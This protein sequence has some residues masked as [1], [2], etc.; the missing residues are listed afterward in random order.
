MSSNR[1]KGIL[2]I[3]HLVI[4]S[5]ESSFTSTLWACL[6]TNPADPDPILAYPD[7]GSC[8]LYKQALWVI[9]S[10]LSCLLSSKA[11][12]QHKNRDVHTHKKAWIFGSRFPARPIVALICVRLQ[13]IPVRFGSRFFACVDTTK[14]TTIWV[15]IWSAIQIVMLFWYVW[16]CLLLAVRD[17]TIVSQPSYSWTKI[18]LNFCPRWMKWLWLYF[19][20]KQDTVLQNTVKFCGLVVWRVELKVLW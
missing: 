8:A 15:V 4:C 20:E 3:I 6:I 19:Y 10:S 18:W 9:H 11:A 16:T 12:T 2:D 7:L 1:T 17:E 14:C 5:T 13:I